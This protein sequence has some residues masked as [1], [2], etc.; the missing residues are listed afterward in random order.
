MWLLY[1]QWPETTLLVISGYMVEQQLR[2][3]YVLRLL[4]EAFRGFCLCLLRRGS[5]HTHQ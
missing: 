5:L 1:H 2:L 4:E 3:S